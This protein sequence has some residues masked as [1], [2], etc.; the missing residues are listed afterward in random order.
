MHQAN[1]FSLRLPENGFSRNFQT[2][3]PKRDLKVLPEIPF[4]TVISACI[5][6]SK[7]LSFSLGYY[8]FPPDPRG[9]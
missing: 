6:G 1:F 8:V 3:K 4:H 7:E 5:T 9:D 2:I